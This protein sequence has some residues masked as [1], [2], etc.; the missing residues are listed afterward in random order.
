[1]TI[2]PTASGI[3]HDSSIEPLPFD[4]GQANTLLDGLGYTK[5]ADG[6]RV[7]NGHP[8]TY[9]VLFPQSERG[10]GDRAFQIIQ[11][12]FQQ[13]GVKLVQKPVQGAYAVMTAPDNKYE[14]WDLA[15]WDWTPPRDPDFIL[16]AMTCHSFG[17]WSDSGYC[18][19]AYDA[20]YAKQASTIDEQAR[21]DIVNQ[22][23]QMVFDDRPYIVLN[24]ND[25]INAWSNNWD[26]FVQSAQGLF[27]ALDKQSLIAVHQ[28]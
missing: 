24:Y 12:D 15:M 27:S 20:L 11:G 28:V 3:W 13:I 1:M 2:V 14:N 19:K 10:A 18:N 8:M 22:M 16:S 4:I 23:Q 7:A 26:G 9:D 5:G 25:T 21:L 6:I 17:N